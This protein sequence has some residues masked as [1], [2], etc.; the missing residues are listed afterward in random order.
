MR[1]LPVHLLLLV[2]LLQGAQGTQT[3]ESPNDICEC[4]I[5]NGEISIDC[6]YKNL[7]T[8]PHFSQTSVV[9]DKLLFSSTE[10]GNCVIG[11]CNRITSIPANAFENITVKH[12]DLLTNPLSSVDLY[13]FNKTG[14]HVLSLQIEAD[15]VNSPYHFFGQMEKLETLYMRN[16]GLTELT[17]GSFLLPLPNLK[18]LTLDT[19]NQLSNIEGTLFSV[20]KNS[21]EHFALKNLQ[22]MT[23]LTRVIPAILTLSNLKMLEIENTGIGTI[24]DQSFRGLN[25]LTELRIQ[26]NARLQTITSNAFEGL[27]GT[28]EYL[29]L[30]SN[31][32]KS[33]STASSLTFLSRPWQKLDHLDLSYNANLG[34]IPA[35]TF[36]TLNTLSWMNLQDIGLSNITDSTFTGLTN[37][38]TLDL[39]YN[40][41]VQVTARSFQNTPSLT[42]LRL[43]HQNRQNHHTPQPL[44]FSENTFEGIEGS[45]QHLLIESNML[46]VTQVWTLISKL[47]NLLELKIDDIGLAEIPDYTF[48][49]NEKLETVTA[50]NNNITSIG[51]A[52]FFGPRETLRTVDLSNNLILT[53]DSCILNDFPV[54]PTLTV[55]GN[56]LDCDCE[57][58]WLYD[59]VHNQA[60]IIEASYIHVGQ[61]TSPDAL[62]GQ[63]FHEFSRTDLCPTST[64]IKTC[65][66]LYIT[67]TTKRPSTTTTTTTTTESPQ[68]PVPEFTFSVLHQGVDYITL[69]W[70][71]Y[72]KTYLTDYR[73]TMKSSSGEED[74]I[75]NIARDD[76][77]YTFTDLSPQSYYTFCLILRIN[78]EYKI[79]EQKCESANTIAPLSTTTQTTVTE[80]PQKQQNLP[81]IIGSSVGGVVLLIIVVLI[82]FVLLKQ[83]KP[84]SKPPAMAVSYNMQHANVPQQGGTAKRFA[85]KPDKEGASADDINVTVISNGDMANKGRISAGSY[86][87]LNEKGVDRSPMP[88]TSNGGY[89]NDTPPAYDHYMNSV[90]SRPLPKE[91]KGAKGHGYVNTQNRPETSTNEYSE[92]TTPQKF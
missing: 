85:K 63:Y 56:P 64:I 81:V 14:H 59:W 19:F 30:K 52:T 36:A 13:A 28:L 34:D 82:V 1:R 32:L 12:I 18:S 10:T 3:C 24:H 72:D 46:N 5:Y 25:K 37:L 70:L 67:T 20:I 15:G 21:T 89:I 77:Q 90:E 86:Q 55:V 45:L 66:N 65:P 87:F 92:I 75:Q 39:S 35:S 74:R 60:D 84:K 42:E 31:N 57:L 22:A 16:Y 68:I 44:V 47:T 43:N 41:I 62:A 73:I 17:L 78:N 48:T 69:T 61:C 49:S 91:P 79:N 51:Q 38:H 80:E 33:A 71:V 4:S 88:S 83:N 76:T 54:K 26:Q 2:T 29:L 58:V 27:E 23:D 6:R 53:L 40:T 11:N 50:S 8:I 7:T 9:Y